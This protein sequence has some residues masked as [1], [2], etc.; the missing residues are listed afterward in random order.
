MQVKHI[1]TAGG[2]PVT[3]ATY[4]HNGQPC[5]SRLLGHLTVPEVEAQLERNRKMDRRTKP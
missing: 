3:E 1:F 4:D 5:C 2:E